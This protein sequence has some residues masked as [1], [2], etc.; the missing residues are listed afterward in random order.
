MSTKPLFGFTDASA[1]IA[2]Q[3]VA[4]S[5]EASSLILEGV[6]QFWTEFPSLLE[7]PL[8]LPFV[9]RLLVDHVSEIAAWINGR[10]PLQWFDEDDPRAELRARKVESASTDVSPLGIPAIRVQQAYNWAAS[11]QGGLRHALETLLNAGLFGL[12]N[13]RSC[14]AG[15]EAPL[16][17]LFLAMAV[18]YSIRPGQPARMILESWGG[19]HPE[20]R[21]SDATP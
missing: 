13:S 16:D 6:E 14:G 3:N 21:N 5:R 15:I 19:N 7:S 1:I 2:S 12:S 4:P 20:R 9:A 17:A 18:D 10:Q 8:D 11:K